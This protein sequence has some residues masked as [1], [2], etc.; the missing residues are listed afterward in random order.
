MTITEPDVARTLVEL[1]T[2]QLLEP[3]M[4]RD[5]ALSEAA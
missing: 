3:F 4:R 2:V 5:M 1:K